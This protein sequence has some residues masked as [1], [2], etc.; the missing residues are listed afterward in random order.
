MSCTPS[1]LIR[2]CSGQVRAW[3]A[4]RQTLFEW[5]VSDLCG[6]GGKECDA[7]LVFFTFSLR[8]PNFKFWW[9]MPF[10]PIAKKE[11]IACALIFLS[12]SLPIGRG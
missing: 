11:S 7:F 8:L 6:H 2:I 9:V 5:A 3:E 1:I 10:E 4:R 12:L